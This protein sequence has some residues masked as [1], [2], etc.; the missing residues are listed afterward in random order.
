MPTRL[1]KATVCAEMILALST[2]LATQIGALVQCALVD[3]HLALGTL[4][5]I[6]NIK[7]IGGYILKKIKKFTPF[8]VF[9]LLFK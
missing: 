9:K 5:Y 3:I 8:A 4:Q 6:L 1:A 7:A 2:I